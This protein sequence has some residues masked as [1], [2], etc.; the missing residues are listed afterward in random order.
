MGREICT[1]L[2]VLKDSLQPMW[3]N[4]ETVRRND[5]KAKEC[6]EKYYNCRY[7]TK[8]L[9]ALNM[10]DKVRLKIAEEKA[11]ATTTTVQG[12]EAMPKSFSLATEWSGD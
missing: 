9:P 4:L 11:W 10:G 3:P 8:P 6:Y 1:T 12:Q 2:P 7:Y 5:A